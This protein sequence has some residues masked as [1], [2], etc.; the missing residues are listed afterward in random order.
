M[1]PLRDT[2]TL[3]SE[4]PEMTMNGYTVL[5][6]TALAILI[7]QPALAQ[8][9]QHA[10]EP[11]MGETAPAMGMMSGHMME[12]MSKGMMMDM[13]VMSFQPGALLGSATVLE[14]SE[15]QVRRLEAIVPEGH[16][17]H[18]EHAQAAMAAR[19][20]ASDALEGDA[21]DLDAYSEAVTEAAGHMAMAHVAMAR[22]AMEAREILT[23]AQRETVA[24]TMS[25]M[26]GMQGMM[27]GMQGMMQHSSM[28]PGGH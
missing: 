2:R 6:T 18:G 3:S 11:Q 4:A 22:T 21:P 14:L 1:V 27:R 26:K 7:G 12:M 17:A 28:G 16:G 15:D 9:H 25:M 20:L 8:Q 19:A 24:D 10:A 23:P 5:L 13:K